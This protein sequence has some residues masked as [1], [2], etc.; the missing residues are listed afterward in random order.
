MNGERQVRSDRLCRSEVI[1]MPQHDRGQ[2]RA[3]RT[4]ADIARLF[5]LAGSEAAAIRELDGCVARLHE[6]QAAKV[7]LRDLTADELRAALASRRAVLGGE[8]A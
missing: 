1:T 5:D 2:G 3:A 7:A 6:V 8:G 4:P